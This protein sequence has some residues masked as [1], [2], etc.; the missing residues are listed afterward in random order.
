MAYNKKQVLQDNINAIATAIELERDNI[1][2]PSDEQIAILRKY[3]GFG[4]LKCVLLPCE[5]EDD[6]KHWSKSEYDLFPMVKEL[7]FI[8][9]E[10]QLPDISYDKMLES[11]KNSVQTAFYTPQ[12]IVQAI[13]DSIAELKLHERGEVL[14]LD[15]SS[16]LGVFGDTFG[17][18]TDKRYYIEK[19]YLTSLILKQVNAN[20]RDVVVQNMPFEQLSIGQSNGIVDIAVSNIPFGNITVFDVEFNRSGDSLKQATTGSLHNYF[21]AKALDAVRP[22][23]IVAFITSRAVL[24]SM[25]SS[26]SRVYLMRHSNIISAIRLPDGMFAA[27]AGTAVGSDLIILQKCDREKSIQGMS[28]REYDF[29][30]SERDPNTGIASS[31][32][33]R[34]DYMADKNRLAGFPARS[35]GTD[36]YGKPAYVYNF[37]GD[38]EGVATK[39]KEMLREDFEENFDQRLYQQYAQGQSKVNDEAEIRHNH[40]RKLSSEEGKLRHFWID[41]IQ[42]RYIDFNGNGKLDGVE[43]AYVHNMNDN[44]VGVLLPDSGTRVGLWISGI[45]GGATASRRQLYNNHGELLFDTAQSRSIEEVTSVVK[46][47]QTFNPDDR[48]FKH[49][50]WSSTNLIAP[51]QSEEGDFALVDLLGVRRI[52]KIVD[53][54]SNEEVLVQLTDRGPGI[55][56]ITMSLPYSS[57]MAVFANHDHFQKI[58]QEERELL[59]IAQGHVTAETEEAELE[60]N[61]SASTTSQ[62]P[63]ASS[64]N[65]IDKAENYLEPTLTEEE[66]NSSQQIRSTKKVRLSKEKQFAVQYQEETGKV[67]KDMFGNPV[68][69]EDSAIRKPIQTK[70]QSPVQSTFD[71]S[72]KEYTG[73]IYKH[74]K[75]AGVLVRE[76]KQIG[77]LI[78]HPL[79]GSSFLPVDFSLREIEQLDLYI[80]VRDSYQLLYDYEAERQ[81]EAT[82]LRTQ[83]NRHYD[84]FVEKYGTLNDRSNKK[85]IRD[86][87]SI[88]KQVFGIERF[89][90]SQDAYVKSD[91][92]Y[93]PVAFFT[94][95]SGLVTT[96]VEAL[97]SSLNRFGSVDMS[98]ICELLPETDIKDIVKDLEGR[99]YWNPLM[100]NYE[101]AETFVAG[102]VIEKAEQVQRWIEE[103]P[104]EA[105]LAEEALIAL[106]EATPPAIPYADIDFSLGERWISSKVYS[107]FAT[108]RFGTEVIVIYNPATD[109]YDV[110]IPNTFYN[111]VNDET[112]FVRGASRSYKGKDMLRYALADTLPNMTK[113]IERENP[114]TGEIQSVKVPD[115]VGL[116]LAQNVKE[117]IRG[118][119]RIWLDSQ[120]LEFKQAMASTY[121]RLFNGR[122]KV[123]FDGSHQT[124]PHLDFSSFSYSELY[125]SQKDAIWMLKVN[126]GGIIDHEVGGGKT[127]IMAVAA[128]EMKRLG[129]V[130]KPMVIT[131][132]ANYK[133]IA[134][135][136]Q[137]AYPNARLFVPDEEDVAG[138]TLREQ[139]FHDI[140]NNEWDMVVLT[141]EN[142]A[143]IPQSLEIEQ[144]I[145]DD[146]LNDVEANLHALALNGDQISKRAYSALERS[147]SNLTARLKKVEDDLRKRKDDVIDFRMMGIDHLFIDES[148]TFKNLTY[149]TRHNNVAGLGNKVGSQRALNLLMA[150]RT[151]QERTGKDLGATFV[152][153]TTVSNSLTELYLLFKYLR[154]R[155]LE[156]QGIR[157]FDAWAAVFA[158][159]SVEYE[160]SVTNEIKQKERFRAFK[161]APELGAFYSEITDF[162]TADDI[163]LDRPEANITL[164]DIP[165]T[166]DQTKYMNNLIEFARTGDARLI[167]RSSLTEQEDK[168]RMLLVTNYAAKMS[169]DMRLIDPNC[170]DDID[171]KASHCAKKVADYY[172]K[173]NEQKGTQ[174]VFSDLGTWKGDNDP[175]FNIYSEIKRKLVE[176]YEIPAN[177]IRFIQEAKSDKQKQEMCQDMNEGKI[178]I[179]FG[180]TKTLGTGVNAQERAVAIHHL[181]TPWVPSAIEQR[182]GRGVR[183]GNWVA[184]EYNDNKVDIYLYAVEQTLDA[185]KFNLLQNKQQFITQLKKNTSSRTIDEGNMDANNGMNYAEFVAVVSG[186]TALLDKVKIERKI[187]NLESV[188][189]AFRKERYAA[190]EKYDA[191]KKRLELIYNNLASLKQDEK[192]FTSRVKYDDKGE[193]VNELTLYDLPNESD[194]EV[195]AKHL[196]TIAEKE[197]TNNTYKRI[198]EVYGFPIMVRSESSTKDG[199]FEFTENRFI[200]KGE[201]SVS[202]TYNNGQL[203]SDPKLAVMN[204]VNALKKIPSLIENTE[205]QIAKVEKDLE[206]YK[207]VLAVDR[208]DKADE[209]ERLKQELVEVNKKIEKTVTNDNTSDQSL[210]QNESLNF[211]QNDTPQVKFKMR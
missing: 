13:S 184:K 125:Q 144:K 198:G 33:F 173:F 2:A 35:I 131:Q 73:Q 108:D 166:A 142:F 136:F 153:G 22:G 21:F 61:I 191:T 154:P 8:L 192:I 147:K 109:D 53:N 60:R 197:R 7:H 70:S 104:N 114:I 86:N 27:E 99:I 88:S 151:I 168:A 117:K 161:N 6:L 98:Y 28:P 112:Y 122:A 129:L 62:T 43:H 211:S 29:I 150:I 32:L 164:Y 48:L 196:H 64:E 55:P 80:K 102:N 50:D 14:M 206:R 204:F 169:L 87:D 90:D 139:A 137:Q 123:K 178:R 34:E 76:G 187:S 78:L 96:P 17:A 69:V 81:E 133:D 26:E 66:P 111:H 210:P 58:R 105:S 54:N 146:E 193:T 1:L 205:T 118:D 152:S 121:N 67:L 19:D 103:H 56:D 126:G 5:V 65:S 172:Y 124:F 203:A 85:L 202:Y 40:T 20:N 132:K 46:A 189:N 128:Y 180:S 41:G 207:A 77:H 51:V 82:E 106:K 18:L 167:G 145:I 119:F 115:G 11:L 9:K 163:G 176:H 15:P 183:T 16:G 116:Q 177:E 89:A 31:V 194:I 110:A 200:V 171:S 71:A 157:S 113:T 208:F 190:Q 30:T 127:M 45:V 186:N 97:T 93:K 52:G 95:S 175:E 148:H 68:V 74:Y 72:I 83:L 181:D 199:M 158:N 44:T 179:M 92:F 38:I 59:E 195:M 134:K 24:D 135:T 42:Y 188:K 3:K 101:L 170:E 79:G 39:I 162:R 165:R 91:I 57:V 49:L 84:A 209:L 130:N 141:H 12:P 149:A 143:K 4:G 23:G 185:Y 160:F 120:P 182:N 37:D 25:S 63:S 75:E 174:F 201:G 10:A 107:R 159:K 138:E 94:N 155:A 36:A 100:G 156:A 140:K 47:M